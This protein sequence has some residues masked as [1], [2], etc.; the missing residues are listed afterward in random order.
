MFK[1]IFGSLGATLSDENPR[2]RRE[3]RAGGRVVAERVSRCPPGYTEAVDSRTGVRVCRPVPTCIPSGNT[4]P[5]DSLVRVSFDWFDHT[6]AA[7]KWSR[8]F[9]V[10]REFNVAP[11]SDM[12][13]RKEDRRWQAWMNQTPARTPSRH[14]TGTRPGPVCVGIVRTVAAAPPPPPPPPSEG[15]GTYGGPSLDRGALDPGTYDPATGGPGSTRVDSDADWIRGNLF[16]RFGTVVPPPETP[17]RVSSNLLFDALFR[18]GATGE[19]APVPPS[20]AETPPLVEEEVPPPPVE[21]PSW[22]VQNKKFIYV[23]SVAAVAIGGY[24]AWRKWGRKKNRSANRRRRNRGRSFADKRG[25]KARASNR[26]AFPLYEVHCLGDGGR[27]E[28][29]SEASTLHGALKT[30][31]RAHRL[32]GQACRIIGHGFF[33]R[34]QLAAEITKS[35]EVLLHE[36]PRD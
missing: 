36:R 35:G 17:P 15:D 29:W 3:G 25:Y 23:A 30:A 21:E 24:L 16:R 7:L 9:V 5:L 27:K 32:T 6:G 10:G 22:F 20:D 33:G 12:I 34:K 8:E 13:A 19:E 14:V 11:T 4:V 1:P 18:R 31:H 26:G 28:E 2:Y